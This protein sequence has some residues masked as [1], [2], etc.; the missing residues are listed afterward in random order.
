MRGMFSRSWKIFKL[1]FGVINKDRELLWFPLLAGIFSLMFIFAM[2]FPSIIL[3]LIKG[4]SLEFGFLF[5][6]AIFLIYLGLAFIATFF[7]VCVVYTT[8]K[9]F[10]GGDAKFMESIK[11]AF[12]RAH[13]IF[14]W[15]IISAS[16]GLLLS[17]IE[18]VAEKLGIFGEIIL[19]LIR[20]LLGAVWA[21]ITIFVVPAMVYHNVGPKKAIKKSIEV[22]K[23]TWGESL[24]RHF[25]LG[26][27]QF[28]SFV[29]LI[30]VIFFLFNIAMIVGPYGPII[31]VILT[32]VLFVLWM[33]IFS[34]LNTIF[35]TALYIYADTGKLIEGYDKE[36]MDSAFKLKKRK[37]F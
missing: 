14:S 6:V 7:N 17:I 11:F 3:S 9:R 30:G 1:S 24:I 33:L 22:L 32:F 35:N 10:E 12:S 20:S 25:G 15:S 21:I 37:V 16:V 34:L 28:F 26:L 2:I 4:E 8:K 13:L 29:I 5:Y 36:T 23:K 18:G 19:K 27:M 31:A